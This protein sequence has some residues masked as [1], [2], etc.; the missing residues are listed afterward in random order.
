MY[1]HDLVFLLRALY[2]ISLL[3][4]R[5]SNDAPHDA[6]RSGCKNHNGRYPRVKKQNSVSLSA[7][8]LPDPALKFIFTSVLV[9]HKISQLNHVR[10]SRMQ[11]KSWLS[12]TPAQPGM[13]RPRASGRY[14]SC[15]CL[16]RSHLVLSARLYGS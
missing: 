8:A 5:E 2:I 13:S 7:Q 16:V 4:G 11:S 10:N 3:W 9:A 14:G 15:V 12:R 1:V 6:R